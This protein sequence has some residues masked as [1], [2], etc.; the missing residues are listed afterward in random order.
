MLNIFLRFVRGTN[1]S[2]ISNLSSFVLVSKFS[3]VMH[4]TDLITVNI[5]MTFLMKFCS[6][7]KSKMLISNMAKLQNMTNM[8][9]EFFKIAPQNYSNKVSFLPNLN[10]NVYFDKFEDAD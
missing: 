8:I 2:F 10:E 1:I 7:L 6:L 9:K 5:E 3:L 4:S